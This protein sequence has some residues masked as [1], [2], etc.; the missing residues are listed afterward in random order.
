MLLL[1]E[2]IGDIYPEFTATKLEGNIRENARNIS[3]VKSL[4]VSFFRISLT[5]IV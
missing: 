5:Q 1:T 4:E 3:M 2:E